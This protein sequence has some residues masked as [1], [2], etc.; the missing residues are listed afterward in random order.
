MYPLMSAPAHFP[1]VVV[2]A[3][4]FQPMSFARLLLAFVD[5][6]TLLPSMIEMARQIAARLHDRPLVLLSV[7]ILPE[8]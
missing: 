7:S 1:A 3:L 5:G 2:L 6:R 4:P 8:R